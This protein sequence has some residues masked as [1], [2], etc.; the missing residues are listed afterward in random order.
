MHTI[1]HYLAQERILPVIVMEHAH[2]ARRLAQTL[3]DAG[4]HTMEITLRTDAAE[5]AIRIASENKS[6]CVGA[7]TV[8]SVDDCKRAVNAGAQYIITPGCNKPVL[9]YACENNITIF[10]G[11]C[12]PSDIDVARSFGLRTLKF[13]PAEAAGGV[14]FLKAISAPY[15][16]TRFVPTG[17]IHAGNL[18]DYLKLPSVLACGASWFVEKQLIAEEQWETIGKRAQDLLSIVPSLD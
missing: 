16:D 3:L 5:E 6:L 17:G 13:F 12:T 2:H 1:D 14:A 11:V 9:Q 7:G 18:A 4:I 10:P 15:G 8:L